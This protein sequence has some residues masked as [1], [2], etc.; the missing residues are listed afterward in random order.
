MTWVKIDDRMPE[1]PKIAGLRDR[2]FRVHVEALCYCAGSLTDGFI[3]EAVAKARGWTR[4][5]GELVEARLW[6][7]AVGGWRI[8]DYLEH[9]RSKEHARGVSEVRAEAGARGGKTRALHEANAKQIASSKSK[10]IRSEE[11]RSETDQISESDPPS[12]PNH[13]DALA[14]YSELASSLGIFNAPIGWA[15]SWL[16]A[17]RSL[18]D[19]RDAIG[20]ARENGARRTA[21]VDTILASPSKRARR[22]PTPLRTPSSEDLELTGAAAEAWLHN[23]VIT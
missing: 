21:Y 13:P 20:R 1:H 6:E 14:V 4:S 16:D 11:I 12:P 7:A 9:Q 19:I 5:A 15:E 22:E 10:Q 17:G 2:A 18:A 23:R 3:P 8:H